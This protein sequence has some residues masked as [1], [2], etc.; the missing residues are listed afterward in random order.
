MNLLQF[1]S[2]RS[3]LLYIFREEV[4]FFEGELSSLVGKLQDF[5]KTYDKASKWLQFPLLKPT[6]EFGSRKSKNNLFARH[7]K[8]IIEHPINQIRLKFRFGT[9][10]SC[11]FSIQKIEDYYM[12]INF[13]LQKK[14]SITIAELTTS[15][16]T[17]IT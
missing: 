12:V 14:S 1:R 6:T 13:F 7:C 4:N 8:D 5:S 2:L 15:T 10:N 17:N 9:N 3:Q 11:V 16:G